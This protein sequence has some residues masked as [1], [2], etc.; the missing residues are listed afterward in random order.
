MPTIRIDDEVFKL[1]G[2][3]VPAN[4]K[5]YLEVLTIQRHIAGMLRRS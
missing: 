3:Q 1:A 5:V 4:G 2:A